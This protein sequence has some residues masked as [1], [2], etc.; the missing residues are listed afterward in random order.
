MQFAGFAKI[1]VEDLREHGAFPMR[2]INRSEARPLIE[3][4]IAQRA[5]DLVQHTIGYCLEYLDECGREIPG[6]MKS[7]IQPSIP[8]MP[9]LPEVSQ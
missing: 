5:Y 3:Q 2:P 9:T 6:S 4:I 7:R 8:D 1:V